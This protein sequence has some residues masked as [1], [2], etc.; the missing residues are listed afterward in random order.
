[1]FK[2]CIIASIMAFYTIA[3]SYATIVENIAPDV[4]SKSP[5]L[6]EE[7]GLKISRGSEEDTAGLERLLDDPVHHMMSPES[8]EIFLELGTGEYI[9]GYKKELDIGKSRI[10]LEAVGENP[11]MEIDPI[12]HLE[13]SATLPLGNKRLNLRYSD[14]IAPFRERKNSFDITMGIEY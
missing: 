12:L 3:S 1:M 10:S 13:G 9:A 11:H 7:H 8:S 6:Y 4:Q 2:R 5:Y 14:E